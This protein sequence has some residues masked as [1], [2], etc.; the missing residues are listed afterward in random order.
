MAILAECPVCHRRQSLKNKV[1]KCGEDLVKAKRAKERVRY[2]IQ[3][4]LPRGKQKKEHVGYSIQ[5]ARDADGKRRGQKRENKIFEIIPAAK[6]TFNELAEWFFRLN[7]VKA[8]RYFKTL[9]YDMACFNA[10]FGDMIVGSIKPSDLE[11]YQ[12]KRKE[13]GDADSYIDAQIGAARN[14]INRA[15][16]NGL[17]GGEVLR[18][19][20][21]VKKLLR[22][23][24]VNARNRILSSEEFHA[25]KEALS[26][27]RHGQHVKAIVLTAYYTGMRKGEIV[28]LTWDKINL[29][30]RMIYLEAE[31]TKDHEPRN[32]PI[33]KELMEVFMALKSRLTGKDNYVFQ[34][35]GRAVFD[36]RMGLRRAC[37]DAGIVYGRYEKGGFVFHDLRRT[38]NTNMRKA[39]VPESVIME[40]TG[41]STREMFDRYNTID[42]QDKREAIQKFESTLEG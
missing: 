13:R 36:I 9:K 22:Y 20:R 18:T 41:H 38:F 10:E 7:K 6:M 17:V 30:N 5:E 28:N 4:R 19:F 35:G 21:K 33:C 25:L 42:D 32:V 29:H 12:V 27:Y 39:G 14:M 1:C 40:I 2:W 23:N 31:D 26:K 16:D 8:R 3:Y 24:S 15:F 37:K 11:N 34:R